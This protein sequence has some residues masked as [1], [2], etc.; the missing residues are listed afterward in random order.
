[1]DKRREQN[2]Q[3]NEQVL[4]IDSLNMTQSSLWL[5]S[6]FTA[7]LHHKTNKQRMTS[8]TKAMQ[9]NLWQTN[10]SSGEYYMKRVRREHAGT[11]KMLCRDW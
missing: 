11:T 2:T 3:I 10:L 1:M 7:S 9:I 6:Q 8:T 5:T 4:V